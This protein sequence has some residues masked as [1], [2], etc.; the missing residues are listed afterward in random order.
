MAYVL[1]KYPSLQL[2]NST[3]IILNHLTIERHCTSV[4]LYADQYTEKI[5]YATCP[6]HTSPDFSRAVSSGTPCPDLVGQPGLIERYKK[7]HPKLSS[8]LPDV[9]SIGRSSEVGMLEDI[10]HKST[11]LLVLQPGGRPTKDPEISDGDDDMALG[12]LDSELDAQLEIDNSVGGQRFPDCIVESVMN[13]DHR[14]DEV[15]VAFSESIGQRVRR[16]RSSRRPGFDQ[17]EPADLVKDANQSESEAKEK[18]KRKEGK[19]GQVEVLMGEAETRMPEMLDFVGDW[20]SQVSLDQRRVRRRERHREGS[21][22]EG[23]GVSKETNENIIKVQSGPAVTEFQKLVD[24][25]QCYSGVA[26]IQTTSSRLSSPSRSYAE[27]LEKEEE[28]GGTSEESHGSRSN[29]EEREQNMNSVDSSRG[30]LPDCVLDWK[31]A[32]NCEVRKS[33]FDNQEEVKTENETTNTTGGNDQVAEIVRE[34]GTV[35]LTQPTNSINPLSNLT[36][37]VVTEL[38]GNGHIDR[39]INNYTD[40]GRETTTEADCSYINDVCQSPVCEGS[41]EAG[42][43]SQERKQRHGRR[44]G[45]QCKLALTFTQNCPASSLNALEY[46]DTTAHNIDSCQSTSKT[47]VEPNFNP[48]SNSSLNSKPDFDQFTKTTSQADKQPLS[49][50]PLVDTGCFTQTEAQDFALLWRLN[51]QDSPDNTLVTVSSHSSDFIVLSGDS[52]RFVPVSAAVAVH[53][54]GHKEVPYRVVHEK[55]TQVEEKELGA[56][57]DRFESLCILSSHFKLVSFDTLE[58]LYDKCHQDLEWTTNL[59]LDS[60]ERFFRDEDGAW[61]EDNQNTFSLCGALGEVVQTNVCAN[62]LGEDLQKPEPA[63]FEEGTQQPTCETVSESNE[64]LSNTDIPCFD[65]VAASVSN[66]HHLNTTSQLEKAPQ[67]ELSQP[68]A[69]KE[70]ECK[71][72]PVPDLGGGAW[73][74]SLEDEVIIEESRTEIEYDI[75]SMDE[76]HRLLQAELEEMERE[77]KQKKEEKTERRDMEER[78]SKHLDIQSLELKLPTELALQLTELFGPVGV[79]PGN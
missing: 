24:L 56:A 79:D 12:D 69:T 57:Q 66:D 64:N 65:G 44:S 52:S 70:I 27:E 18:E 74:G 48:T 71:V 2:S 61:D 59:L 20:P 47:E 7:S 30:E 54:S 5:S 77:E 32:D 26:T 22:E 36:A 23:D 67:T 17:K 11:E 15:P 34:T 51:R 9:S 3:I 76:V 46:P 6:I 10:T 39:S 13:E 29:S 53:P 40:D 50:C 60:G 73:G 38:C 4:L 25:I 14:G 63:E 49:P 16:E 21:G 43:G 41:V 75:A 55:G 37:E 45:K 8:S 28:A 78:R 62:V 19:T 35:D 1:I 58:D 72:M 31:A 33:K 68:E 42:L